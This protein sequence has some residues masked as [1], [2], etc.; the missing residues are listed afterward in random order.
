M[1]H[2]ERLQ[3]IE[4]YG[5]YHK[6]FSEFL[7]EFPREMWKYKPD[8]DHWCV[9]EIILHLLDTEMNSYVRYR[10]CIA[11]PGKTI[12]TFDQDKWSRAL[13]Y[14]ERD[15]DEAIHN[16]QG[17]IKMNYDLLKSLP[18]E[19]FSQSVLHPER[20][21]QTLDQALDVYFNHIPHHIEQMRKRLREWKKTQK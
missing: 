6:N 16:L 15:V 9:H 7:R 20:G 2:S 11:E 17:V 14:T 4:N 13:K 5:V 19:T 18:E 3:K 1:S 8:A 12:T 21:V 10:T